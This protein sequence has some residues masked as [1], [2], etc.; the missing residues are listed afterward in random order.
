MK[1]IA[2][3]T[4]K[5]IA[6]GIEKALISMLNLIPKDEYEVT[7]FVMAK[8]GEFE[9]LIPKH[10]KIKCVFGDEN[11]TKEKVI[12]N[13]RKGQ[14]IQTCRVLLYTKLALRAKK[15][16]KQEDYFLKISPV[17]NEV[18]D[19]AIAYHTPASFPV[20]Y[21]ANYLNAK[22]KI[23][24]IHSDIEEYKEEMKLYIDYYKNFNRIFC[25]SKYGLEKFTKMYPDFSEKTRL[26]YNII[27]ENEL[28]IL[29][30]EGD[31]FE[32]SFSGLRIL[33]VG[34]L[35]DQ[36]GYD[37]LPQIV[38][39]LNSDGLDIRWYCIGE[40]ELRELLEEK[41]IQY[42][43]QQRLILLG[44]KTNPY[45]YFKD[46]D[47]YVQPSRHEGYCITL[48]E[49]RYFCKPI[50]TTDFVGAR[51]QIDNNKTGSIVKFD[52]DDVYNEVRKLI[53]SKDIREKYI[54]NLKKDDFLQNDIYEVLKLSEGI[55]E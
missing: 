53:H 18:Y 21:V 29:A 22:Q 41:I 33:T 8:G 36:K 47:I 10:V 26:F 30:D 45:P 13:L 35:T 37:I 49:A 25:V 24:W 5:M 44:S 11:S 16:S 46:C 40:G 12:N 27:N 42:N 48:A 39:D 38:S 19:L 1:K 7:L 17:E 52:S 54:K 32:D 4:R 50:V 2:I 14:F 51:E 6:G 9:K 43:L 55:L 15:I 20:K 23:A 34:R 31:S 3:V 28:K